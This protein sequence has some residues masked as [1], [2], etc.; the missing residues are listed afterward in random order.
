MP[1]PTIEALSILERINEENKL[2]EAQNK[3]RLQVGIVLEQYRIARHVLEEL[4]VNRQTLEESIARLT[5][6]F[7]AGNA[8][9][10]QNLAAAR[11]TTEVEIAGLAVRE[12]EAK[13]KTVQ[14]EA[15]LVTQ[16]ATLVKAISE[17]NI[18]I[19]ELIERKE[20]L[21]KDIND[22]KTKHG[23]GG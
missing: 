9:I 17:L 19:A 16:Q 8:E 10:V 23:L 1:D 4:E 18:Q 22:L 12:Q 14:A 13:E 5:S 2:W 3:A 21:L 7:N 15:E 6:R 20:N 11:Q